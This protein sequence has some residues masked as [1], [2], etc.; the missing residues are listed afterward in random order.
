ML[1]R[2]FLPIFSQKFYLLD[3]CQPFKAP[4]KNY[5]NRVGVC[6]DFKNYLAWLTGIK[7]LIFHFNNFFGSGHF[8]IHEFWKND[9]K[10]AG[11]KKVVKMKY[12]FFYACQPREVIFEIHAHSCSIFLI[13]GWSFKW[14]AVIQEIK[15]LPENW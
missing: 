12:Q 9:Q 3:Y 11:A 13:F 14:L 2:L 10:M 8:S 7:K 5:E 15:F 6:M 4:A 1:K